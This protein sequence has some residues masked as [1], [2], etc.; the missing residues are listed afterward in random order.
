MVRKVDPGRDFM[1]QKFRL[2]LVLPGSLPGRDGR[3]HPQRT[4]NT[5]PHLGHSSVFSILGL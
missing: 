3:N 1:G 5:P 4:F 2:L